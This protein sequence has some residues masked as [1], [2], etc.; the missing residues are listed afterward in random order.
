MNKLDKYQI[1]FNYLEKLKDENWLKEHASKPDFFQQAFSISDDLIQIYYSAACK[2]MI[3]KRWEDAVDAFTFLTF[4]SPYTHNFWMGLGMSN[5][6]L[7]KY[8]EA[9][10]AYLMAQAID[11]SDPYSHAN[12]FQCSAALNDKEAANE[13]LNFALE[14]C[15]DKEEYSELKKNLLK[16]VSV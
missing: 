14:A 15:G 7:E 11:F 1:D 13:M 4:I 3:E 9:R 2:L 5:Q 6:S 12:S 10:N 8:E 16:Y